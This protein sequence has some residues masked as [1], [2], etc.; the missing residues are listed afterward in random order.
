MFVTNIYNMAVDMLLQSTGKRLSASI[1]SS[2]RSGLIFI[3]C[4]LILSRIFGLK[5]IQIAQSVAFFISVIPTAFFA[6]H[7]FKNL[8]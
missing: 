3:P 5:G 2:L 8:P 1:V 7:F 6:R 4:I